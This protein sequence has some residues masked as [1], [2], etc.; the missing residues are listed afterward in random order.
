M[1]VKLPYERMVRTLI[2]RG[3]SPQAIIDK[4]REL[5]FALPS[6]I[7]DLCKAINLRVRSELPPLTD[8]AQLSDELLIMMD[9]F[10]LYVGLFDAPYDPRHRDK[11][12][13]YDG[14]MRI[15]ED[16]KMRR[17]IQSMALAGIND[18]DIELML[19]ARYD[20]N[21]S[22]DDINFYLTYFFDVK[23]WRVPQLKILVDEE[24]DEDFKKMYMLALKGDKGYLLWKLGMAPNR[25]YQE[26]L[27]D[28]M[29]DA[30]YLFKETAKSGH[31][32]EVA[33][34]WSQLAVKVAEKLERNDKETADSQTLYQSIEFNIQA[35]DTPKNVLRAE[36]LGEDLPELS[37]AT[38]K[39]KIPTID[40][41]KQ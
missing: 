14:A 10:P 18:E 34:R 2:A 30:Y 1:L 33:H 38:D 24:P 17:A 40:R 32:P 7:I 16:T 41:T 13:G 15:L 28:M 8:G 31:N 35:P 29:N 25:S 36:D 19:N 5:Q 3:L 20:L 22:P 26:M 6:N 21:Y 39:T 4:L 12:I 9:I 23:S 11:T 27:Q 37:Q